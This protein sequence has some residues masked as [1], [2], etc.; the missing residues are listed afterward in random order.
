LTPDIQE[1]IDKVIEQGTGLFRPPGGSITPDQTD[2][3][4]SKI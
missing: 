2:L 3:G 1:Y 4:S